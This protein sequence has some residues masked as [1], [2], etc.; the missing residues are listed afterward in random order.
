M[1]SFTIPMLLTIGDTEAEWEAT[2][3]YRYTKPTRGMMRGEPDEPGYCSVYQVWATRLIHDTASQ[4]PT[5]DG[6]P[7]SIGGWLSNA[8]I[9]ALEER[10]LKEYEKHAEPDV[11]AVIESRS[12]A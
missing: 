9:T 10:A 12:A 7:V 5:Y 1:L 4:R 2:V 3:F 8:Q 6:K 11:E